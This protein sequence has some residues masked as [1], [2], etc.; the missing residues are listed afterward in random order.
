MSLGKQHISIIFS[1]L[2]KAAVNVYFSPVNWYS[3]H[4]IT[5]DR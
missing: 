1:L 4:F 5:G 2:N 3:F